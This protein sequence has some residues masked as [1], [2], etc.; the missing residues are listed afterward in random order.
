MHK[1]FAAKVTPFSPSHDGSQ[2]PVKP[3]LLDVGDKASTVCEGIQQAA[4]SSAFH[5]AIPRHRLCSQLQ[6][7]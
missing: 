5:L 3:G 1:L 6:L 4:M 7:A 2:V